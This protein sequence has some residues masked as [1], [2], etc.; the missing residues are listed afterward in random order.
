LSK[1][2]ILSIGI[3]LLVMTTSGAMAEVCE[4]L[5]PSWAMSLG[6]SEGRFAWWVPFAYLPKMIGLVGITILGWYRGWRFILIGVAALC[7]MGAFGSVT[8][9]FFADET[10]KAA[11]GMAYSEGCSSILAEM[12][13]TAL[14]ALIVMAAVTA[15]G[16]PRRE[17]P[18]PLLQN[19]V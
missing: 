14:H 15:I 4:K 6:F 12:L 10:L 2:R 1:F 11:V 18:Q 19:P 16:Y 9:L 5:L 3:T 8:K 13:L 17:R 7:V